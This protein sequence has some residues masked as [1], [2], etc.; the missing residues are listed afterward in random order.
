MLK[1]FENTGKEAMQELEQVQSSEALEQYRIKYLGRKGLITKLLSKIGE[2][3]PEDRAEAGKLANKIKNE[4]NQAFKQKQKSLSGGESGKAEKLIEDVTLPGLKPAVGKQHVIS[5]TVNELLDIF[6]RMGFGIAYGPE[7]E[8]EW[9]NFIALN[10]PDEHPARDPADNFYIDEN[11]LL[12]SQTSTI[13]IRVMESQKPPIRVVAPGRVYRPDT[14]DATH[15]FMFH[16]IEAL[17]VDE[18]V[19]MIDLKTTV[20]Q[21][22]RTFFGEDTKWRFRPSFFPFTEP[23]AEIDLLF[24][25][26]DGSEQWIEIGGCGMVD[27]NVFDSVGIDSEKYTG[28]AF[29][30][31]I[32]R[33]AMRKFGIYDIRLLYENDLRF[34]DQF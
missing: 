12:R 30:L 16:Q 10:I 22:V 9:H 27:P 29:G 21:F 28:W 17:V 1:D 33:L 20:D 31:G 11:T 2:V 23:S 25:N 13:Q 5:N 24:H 32:E 6:G 18:G 26:K 34:L 15:M 19:S 14:V 4:V 8:D 3:A 7:V